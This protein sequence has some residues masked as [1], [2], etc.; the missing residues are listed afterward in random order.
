MGELRLSYPAC[1][2][3]GKMRLTAEDIDILREHVFVQGLTSS[4]DAMIL[5]AINTSCGE[6]CP[7][8]HHYFIDTMTNFIVRTC[9]PQGAMDEWNADWLIAMISTRGVV[10]SRIELDLLFHIVDISHHIPDSLSIFA[11]EQIRLAMTEDIGIWASLRGSRQHG[12][13][14]ADVH[15]I[16]WVMSAIARSRGADLTERERRMLHQIGVLTGVQGDHAA[17]A[18]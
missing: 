9:Y 4:Q 3:A 17:A 1:V 6:K 14:V 5:L 7:E 18:A 13:Q 15:L 11:L 16:S 10:N 8:W 12:L 2:I